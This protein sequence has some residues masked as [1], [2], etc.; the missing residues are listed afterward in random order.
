MAGMWCCN[1]GIPR[2][3]LDNPLHLTEG[4]RR[5]LFSLPTRLCFLQTHAWMLPWLMEGF[6]FSYSAPHGEEDGP[7][8]HISLKIWQVTDS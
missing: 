3:P 5:L 8:I 2:P 7:K 4:G 1:C 6:R